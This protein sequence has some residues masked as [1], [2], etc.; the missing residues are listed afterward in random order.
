MPTPHGQALALAL[1]KIASAHDRP[2]RVA[3]KHAPARFHLIVYI[4]DTDKPREP[5]E[6]SYDPLEGARVNVLTIA[7]DVP[8]AR[9]HEACA[10]RRIVEHRLGSPR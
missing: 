9:E 10:R 8:S 1:L 3:G 7:G 6:R 5:T 4:H 2:P